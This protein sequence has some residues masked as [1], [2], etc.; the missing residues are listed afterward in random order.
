MPT[1]Y[2][3]SINNNPIYAARADADAAGNSIS[4]TYATKSE[5]PSGVPAVT[6]SDNDKVLKATYS[7]GTGSYEWAS[8]PPANAIILTSSSTWSDF[9]TPYSA[10]RKDIYFKYTSSA[11]PFDYRAELYLHLTAVSDVDGS[12]NFTFAWFEGA[13]GDGG[14]GYFVRCKF[15]YSGPTL[16]FLDT[17]T[18]D[19]SYSSSSNRAQ[20]GKAVA[21][22]I[23]AVSQVPASTSADENKVL[24]VDSNGSPVWADSQGGTQVQS[25]WTESDTTDPSYIQHKPLDIGITEGTGITFTNSGASVAIGVTIPVPSFD[26]NNDVG[27]VLKITSGGVLAWV[28]P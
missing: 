5:L 21:Q 24:T 26:P 20:S 12:S 25:D 13:W 6:S 19:Q 1:T 28:T 27:K 15:R 10:G 4:S 11:S 23:S 3:N 17:L 22:A 18:V 16:Y 14:N 2:A 9:H 8:N 7:G